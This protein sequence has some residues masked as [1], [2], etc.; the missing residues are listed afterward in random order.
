MSHKQLITRWFEEVWNKKR[1]SAVD[2]ML[3]PKVLIYGIP[4]DVI[5]T[6]AEFKIF[7]KSLLGAFP[8]LHVAVDE[9]IEEGDRVV[10]RCTVTGT[11]TGTGM[12]APTNKAISFTGTCIAQVHEGKMVGGWNHFDFLRL[13]DQI[14]LVKMLT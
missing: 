5:K 12:G 11:H 14:G 3:A 8:D 2:E 9:T 7:R 10:A 6:P 4:G 1:E 13:Y